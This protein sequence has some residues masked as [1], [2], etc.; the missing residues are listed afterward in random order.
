MVM[1]LNVARFVSKI[2]QS[3]PQPKP[4]HIESSSGEPQTHPHLTFDTHEKIGPYE[5]HET[6]LC[7]DAV[8]MK[9]L[10]RFTRN[11]LLEHVCYDELNTLVDEQWK[12]TICCRI[13]GH[14]KTYR[15]ELS[16]TACCAQS[17]KPDPHQPV[18]LDKIKSVPGLMT[19]RERSH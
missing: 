3:P 7:S 11:T 14:S 6:Y 13:N 2:R 8:D 10:L 4:H 18:A 1:S 15:V 12:Y 9:L 5:L 19:I 16:Y 17:V